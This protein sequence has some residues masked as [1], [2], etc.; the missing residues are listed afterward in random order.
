MAEY[1]LRSE[2]RARKLGFCTRCGQT[3]QKGQM[4]MT[5]GRHRHSK[6]YHLSC[7]ESMFID[8]GNGDDEYE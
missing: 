3:F 1:K 4:V 6:T 7:W 2:T 5:R 8:I